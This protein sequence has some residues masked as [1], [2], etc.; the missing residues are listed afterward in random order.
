LKIND[1]SDG[2][3]TNEELTRVNDAFR[4]E[5]PIEEKKQDGKQ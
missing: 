3:A 4:A 2:G 5:N 1:E